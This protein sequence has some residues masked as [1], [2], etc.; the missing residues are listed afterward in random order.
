MKNNEYRLRV[1]DRVLGMCFHPSHYVAL[2]RD[3]FDSESATENPDILLDVKIRGWRTE[4]DVDDSLFTS[5]V[6]KRKR[7]Q[8]S[9]G[10]VAGRFDRDAGRG[11]IR[12]HRVLTEVP[13]IRVFEQLLYQAFYSLK[14]AGHEDAFLIHSCGIIRSGRG[15]LF[16]GPPESGKRPKSF[17]SAG[18]GPNTAS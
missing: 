11:T 12:M 5:K 1:H 18:R 17:S 4:L 13:T 16:A 10:L 15:Y 2:F 14:P 3:Y 8:M 9:G 7:F 6:Q